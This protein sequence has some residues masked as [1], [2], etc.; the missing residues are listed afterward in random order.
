MLE[1]LASHFRDLTPKVDFCSL[2]FVR[3][4]DE[5][6]SVRQG[7]PEPARRWTDA[8]AM[9]TVL[10]GGG[11]G[12]AATSDLSRPG[13]A[14]VIAGPVVPVDIHQHGHLV[15]QVHSAVGSA[16]PVRAHALGD[17]T[18][19]DDLLQESVARRSGPSAAAC[20]LS[21]QRS[22]AVGAAH[23]ERSGIPSGVASHPARVAI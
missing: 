8:G 9:I 19:A 3:E 16:L 20:H 13:L 6:V 22:A 1:K 7:V 15:V 14:L 23:A 17:A 21:G 18:A 4:C 5:I 12:Y 11:M 2:R 10:D